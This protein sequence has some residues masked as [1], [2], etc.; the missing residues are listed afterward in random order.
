[1]TSGRTLCTSGCVMVWLRP[2]L[3]PPGCG[4]EWKE[5][6]RK[7]VGRVKGSLTEQQ[8]K[9]TVTTTIQIKGIHK[10]HPQKRATLSQTDART[11]EPRVSSRCAA[12]P[13]RNPA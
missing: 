1:M 13:H 4:G 9:G 5:T 7:L 2:P 6:G 12:P 3:P 11:A 8:T 10:K